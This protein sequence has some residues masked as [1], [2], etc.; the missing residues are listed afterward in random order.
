MFARL[1]ELKSKAAQEM[2]RSRR[3]MPVLAKDV[4]GTSREI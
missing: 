1:A 2:S 3:Q 4:V